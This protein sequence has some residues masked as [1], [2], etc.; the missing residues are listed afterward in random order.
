MPDL[1]RV[2]VPPPASWRTS[3]A[4][5]LQS[6]TLAC[7]LIGI[8]VAGCSGSSSHVNADATAG[9]FV[10]GDSTNGLDYSSAR[11]LAGLTLTDQNRY[12]RAHHV[13]DTVAQVSCRTADA[14]LKEFR[15]TTRYRDQSDAT[16]LERIRANGSWY[17]VRPLPASDE[18][19]SSSNRASSKTTG[20]ATNA[21]FRWSSAQISN[22]VPFCEDGSG[23]NAEGCQPRS[24][25][26][27]RSASRLLTPRDTGKM[28]CPLPL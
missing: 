2:T 11:G 10:A 27:K 22:Y 13:T 12:I 8:S 20:R 19:P 6:A 5:R 9:T 18:V 16:G 23:A 7:G 28:Y 4:L 14:S 17:Q 21:S 15:C 24:A 3:C 1:P 26:S 25:S